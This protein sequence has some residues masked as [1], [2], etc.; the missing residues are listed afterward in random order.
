[1]R[2]IQVHA[3]VNLL[4]LV[5]TSSNGLY[6]YLA[7]VR[8][9][10]LGVGR[11]GGF[12]SRRFTPAVWRGWHLTIGLLFFTRYE[13]QYLG[14]FISLDSQPCLIW[15]VSWRLRS[16][17]EGLFNGLTLPFL[18]EAPEFCTDL[19]GFSYLVNGTSSSFDFAV[20]L[21]IS[22]NFCF[23]FPCVHED[24]KLLEGKL[25]ACAMSLEVLSLPSCFVFLQRR[26]F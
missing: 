22:W 20:L 7:I 16:V 23:L 19:S 14:Y 1:M 13:V 4:S 26:S 2:F 6:I 24:P 18:E 8:A 15:T 3:L 21:A 5:D 12:S 25:R 11:W 10:H 17:L 9:A